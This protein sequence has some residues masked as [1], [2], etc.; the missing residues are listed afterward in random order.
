MTRLR[1]MSDLHLEFGPLD[2]EPV[3]EDVLVLAG[4]IG[5]GT[6]GLDWA[7]AY[8]RQTGVA[9]IM[10]A[11][12]HEFYHTPG[13]ARALEQF[14]G[15]PRDGVIFM[16][17]N[18]SFT[19]MGSRYQSSLGIL[20]L[21]GST[22]WTD[23]RL[24]NLDEMERIG[25]MRYAEGTMND[26]RLIPNFKPW[27][28]AQRHTDSRHF[29]TETLMKRVSQ[30]TVVITHHLPSARSIH[31]RYAGDPANPAFASD[32]DALVENSGAALWVHGHTH[33][34]CDYRIGGT[35]VLCN[36]RGYYPH[37]LNP[38]FDPNLV[39]EI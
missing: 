35:R 34:S 28:A 36:P 17:D 27:D 33:S 30:P 31:P 37:E 25:A 39:V 13:V 6:Q 7:E 23:Y 24:G 22:L 14:R 2:L 20:R 5:I 16:E 21:I 11:G 38:D 3:G 10:I 32:L 1:I 26:H 19:G 18:Q 15:D 29:I 9:S 12:N 4:D 8:Y